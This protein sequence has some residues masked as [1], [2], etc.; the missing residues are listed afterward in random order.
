MKKLFLDDENLTINST[1]YFDGPDF[2]HLV[3]VLR[4]KK[5]ERIVLQGKN[6]IEVWGK[7]EDVNKAKNYIKFLIER[8]Y[9][10]KEI[11]RPKIIVFFSLLKGEKNEYLIQKCTEIGVDEF[12]P[13][14]TKNSIP[15]IDEKSSVKKL[16]RFRIVAKEASMQSLREKIPLV[17]EIISFEKIRN[18]VINGEKY[19]GY[20]NPDSPTVNDI[21]SELTEKKEIAFFVGPEGDFS[22]EE[23]KLLIDWGWKGVNI[24]Q[25]ILKSDTAAI[26][27]A[28]YIYSYF[29]KGLKL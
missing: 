29:Y 10:R 27:F 18:Y 3:N 25:Y 2:H 16:E 7:V 1:V 21:A 15:K 20:I 23:I 26:L 19:F 24:S 4:I 17:N 22:K 14:L 11:K 13:V 28:S 8:E 12:F 6:N 9:I 5:G